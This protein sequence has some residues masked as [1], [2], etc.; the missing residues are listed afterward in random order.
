MSVHTFYGHF[1][2]FLFRAYTVRY[3]YR[4]EFYARI[5]ENNE[6]NCGV[7][8]L[9]NASF[10]NGSS[11]ASFKCKLKK[12]T[13]V[14][15]TYENVSSDPASTSFSVD[16]ITISDNFTVTTNFTSSRI[17]AGKSKCMSMFVHTWIIRIQSN[18]Q[19]R[20]PPTINR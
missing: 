10:L 20:Y 19:N 5:Y 14:Y 7:C 17:S 2:Y 1:S 9:K 4:L 12:A 6:R 8:K 3:T 15:A 11:N 18:F 13:C 16:N